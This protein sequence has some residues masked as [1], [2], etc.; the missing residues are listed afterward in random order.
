MEKN[1]GLSLIELILTINLLIIILGLLFSFLINNI[2]YFNIIYNRNEIKEQGEFAINYM[3][4]KLMTLNEITDITDKYNY[5][6]NHINKSN[7]VNIRR[8]IFRGVNTFKH[9]ETNYKFELKTNNKLFDRTTEVACYITDIIISPIPK[10]VSYKNA[11]GIKIILKLN[12]DKEYREIS[13]TVFFRN[14]R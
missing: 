1:K 2:N 9:S 5:T 11:E 13:K 10:E 7:P 4:E 3:T 8:I 6:L 12:K 14:R